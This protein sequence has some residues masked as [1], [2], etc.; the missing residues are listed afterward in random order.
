MPPKNPIQNIGNNLTLAGWARIATIAISVLAILATT[1]A[2]FAFLRL[3]KQ[4]DANSETV[5]KINDKLTEVSRTQ[6]VTAI[7]LDNASHRIDGLEM[8]ERNR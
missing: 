1:P 4:L 5:D 7:I 3:V 2:A 6:A 8:R